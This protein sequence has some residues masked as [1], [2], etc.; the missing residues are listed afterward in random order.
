LFAHPLTGGDRDCL[1]RL[2]PGYGAD[3]TVMADDPVDV[4][5]DELVSLPVLLTVVDGEVVFRGL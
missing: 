5:G 3:V 4:G 1:G 2:I